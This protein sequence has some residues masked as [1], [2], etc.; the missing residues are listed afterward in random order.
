MRTS[1]N[2]RS[3]PSFPSTT[4]PQ[5][6]PLARHRFLFSRSNNNRAAFPPS[7]LALLNPNLNRMPV[8]LE[9]LLPSS[10]QAALH[11]DKHNSKR[12]GPLAHPK[13]NNKQEAFLALLRINNSRAASSGLQPSRNLGVLHSDKHSKR[14]NSQRNALLT[15]HC[16][17]ASRSRDRQDSQ[18]I[19]R[20]GRKGVVSTP[21]GQYPCR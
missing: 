4:H 3:L 7:V 6:S 12:E 16:D 17:L 19:N 13:T 21:S 1:R 9:P 20:Y 11:L 14:T 15:R 5:V 2:K 18:G 8:F 10:S